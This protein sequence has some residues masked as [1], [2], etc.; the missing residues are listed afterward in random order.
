MVSPEPFNRPIAG[1]VYAANAAAMMWGTRTGYR[2][3]GIDID[4]MHAALRRGGPPSVGS[5]RNAP[6]GPV[7]WSQAGGENFQP[8]LANIH[9]RPQDNSSDTSHHAHGDAY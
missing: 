8:A 7:V 3:A 5:D 9:P 2:P 6:R 1:A 4:S